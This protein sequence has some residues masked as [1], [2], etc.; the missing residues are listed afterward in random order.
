ME[1]P[2]LTGT[3]KETDVF[4]SYS[5]K[6]RPFAEKLACDL[7]RHG[8]KVWIDSLEMKVG[9]SLNKKIQNGI[10]RSGWLAV[11]LSPYSVAS[12]WVEKE[13]NAAL[14]IELEKQSVFVLP[15]LYKECRIP[16]FLQDKIY[17]DFRTSYQSGLDALFNKLCPPLDSQGEAETTNGGETMKSKTT[18]NAN[19]A[20]MHNVSLR[21]L[22]TAIDDC[23]KEKCDVNELRIFA[24]NSG[25]ILP[26]IEGLEFN[27]GTCNVL[28]PQFARIRVG[29]DGR[30]MNSELPQVKQ[31]LR[32]WKKLQA[33]GRIKKLAVK[34]YDHLPSHYCCIFD[35]SAMVLGTYTYRDWNVGIHD[36]SDALVLSDKGGEEG[37]VI[38]SFTTWFDDVWHNAET[39]IASNETAHRE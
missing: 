22:T 2:N 38:R 36:F 1:S 10:S 14:E 23:T 7:K 18:E 34:Y 20:L 27:I 25:T 15:V 37:S 17:A 29:A 5:W 16:L 4:I 33:R 21:T 13:L 9:D 32:D 30:L 6:D 19:K 3:T 8:V 39:D 24:F 28:L 35:K 11:V 12:A 31:V 26:I